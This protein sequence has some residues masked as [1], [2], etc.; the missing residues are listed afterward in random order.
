MDNQRRGP[1]S[2]EE[3]DYIFN[4][5]AVETIADI[6]K[7]LQR[8]PRSVKNFIEKKNLKS[9][10][11]ASI[12]DEDAEIINKLHSLE[13]WPSTTNSFTPKELRVFE[14]LWVKIFKQFDY[15]VL[16]SEELQLRKFITIEILKDR[17]LQKIQVS[18]HAAE[19]LQESYSSE[20]ARDSMERDKDLMKAL[21]EDLSSYRSAIPALNKEYADLCKEQEVIQKGLSA[22]RNDRIKNIQDSTKNWSS[23]LKMLEDP[24]NRKELGKFIEIMNAARAKEMKR[25]TELHK[26]VDGEYDK[27]ILSGRISDD[28]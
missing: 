5:A 28:A 3:K 22:S 2:A 11:D 18:I 25:L 8:N 17:A 14:S 7:H 4:K 10:E 26:F 9:I 19:S 1:L 21:R 15:D 6:A 16:A 23:I 13:W 27:P 24:Q 12:S 20:L